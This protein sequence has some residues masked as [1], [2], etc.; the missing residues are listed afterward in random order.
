MKTKLLALLLLIGAMYFWSDAKQ[1]QDDYYRKNENIFHVDS[2]SHSLTKRLPTMMQ[3][4]RI[5]NLK[6]FDAA[7]QTN[8]N[9]DMIA[10]LE[11][12]IA[13]RRNYTQTE[14]SAALLGT[15]I[16]HLT[17]DIDFEV[18]VEHLE[19]AS[20]LNDAE[21]QYHLGVCNYCGLGV[22]KNDS[23]AI[24]WLEKSA[25]SGTIASQNLLSFIHRQSNNKAEE[26]KWHEK[27]EEQISHIK[28]ST[29]ISQFAHPIK[30]REVAKAYTESNP[31]W[32]KIVDILAKFAIISLI[33]LIFNDL[34]KWRANRKDKKAE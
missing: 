11:S 3:E 13:K 4:Q 26:V 14:E 33:I 24:K 7:S 23:I 22:D 31:L 10:E 9:R 32:E 34:R 12:S 27:M 6:R 15:A 8:S 25:N 2:L 1:K 21:A 28:D 29:T 17:N 19:R 16:S 18:A 5:E 30:Y 20:A